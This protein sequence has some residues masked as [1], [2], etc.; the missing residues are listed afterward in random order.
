MDKLEIPTDMTASEKETKSL[1][2][3]FP[4]QTRASIMNKLMYFSIPKFLWIIIGGTV[5]PPLD[6][7]SA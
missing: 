1:K 5:V 6:I 2:A 4:K 7:L 3:K